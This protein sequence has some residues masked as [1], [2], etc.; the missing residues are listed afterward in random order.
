MPPLL[1]TSPSHDTHQFL[2]ELYAGAPKDQWLTLFSLDRATG[3]PGIR[4]HQVSCI[5]E[6]VDEAQIMAESACVWFGIATR[7]ERLRAGRGGAEDC[8]YIPAI[9]CDIDVQGPNHRATN[10]PPTMDA[11]RE[12]IAKHPKP[13]NFVVETG[14]GLQP[15]WLLDAPA[16]VGDEMVEFLDKWRQTWQDYSEERGWTIDNTWDI[17]RRLSPVEWCGSCRV[18]T[19]LASTVSRFGCVDRLGS[20]CIGG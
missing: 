19:V 1:S 17:A 5:G 13:P 10:L 20:N 4:W 2:S 18:P 16:K 11:A 3:R 14:G 8:G 12:L 7:K 15:Y 9:W 6:M